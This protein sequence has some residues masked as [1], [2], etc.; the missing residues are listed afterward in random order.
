MWAVDAKES[1]RAW[2]ESS[3]WR[4]LG[5]RDLERPQLG[6][7]AFTQ[8]SNVRGSWCGRGEVVY[9]RGCAYRLHAVG[10]LGGTC[11]AHPLRAPS[12]AL[13][14]EALQKPW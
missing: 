12:V 13:A 6:A 14:A 4:S 7:E 5:C 8:K 10:T 9:E 3:V 2:F 11:Q 1:T